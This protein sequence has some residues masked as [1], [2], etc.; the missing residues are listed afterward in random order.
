M[1][2][3]IVNNVELTPLNNAFAS[4]ITQ[5]SERINLCRLFGPQGPEQATET[6][7]TANLFRDFE[8]FAILFALST[9]LVGRGSVYPRGG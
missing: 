5:R 6:G 3:A 8:R 7:S 4:F 1:K 9:R 2:I